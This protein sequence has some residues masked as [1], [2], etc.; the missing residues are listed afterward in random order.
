MIPELYT[1]E[2]IDAMTLDTKMELS[3]QLLLYIQAECRSEVILL[4]GQKG[5]NNHGKTQDRKIRKLRMWVQ[6]DEKVLIMV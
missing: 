5:I 1:F 6:T 4:G 2:K 3:E